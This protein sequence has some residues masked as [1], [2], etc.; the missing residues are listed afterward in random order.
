M[1][2]FDI[3]H[4]EGD[5]FKG[6]MEVWLFD[7]EGRQIG[8]GTL[9]NSY[10]LLEMATGEDANRVPLSRFLTTE[11]DLPPGLFLCIAELRFVDE[12]RRSAARAKFA[13]AR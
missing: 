5:D 2:A 6:T 8:Y 7:L 1:L 3:F 4:P 10:L 12:G 13:V 11:G 9:E